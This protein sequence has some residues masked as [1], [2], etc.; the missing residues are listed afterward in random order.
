MRRARTASALLLLVG[1]ASAAALL[2]AA[3]HRL[4]EVLMRAQADLWGT[5][6][7]LGAALWAAGP[8]PRM[9]RAGALAAA[10]LALVS[11]VPRL[12]ADCR[13]VAL[14]GY[15]GDAVEG[16]AYPELL[17]RSRAVLKADPG[18]SEAAV[19]SAG[20]LAF[21]LGRPSEALTLLGEAAEGSPVDSSLAAAAAGIAA[22]GPEDAPQALSQ[23]GAC[24]ALPDCPARIRRNAAF[25]RARL[26]QQR[27]PARRQGP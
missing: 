26:L 15:Y 10:A 6:A 17:A 23:L 12:H 21:H 11:T 25:L 5:G 13:F 4:P 8:A 7:A 22:V 2:A 1:A 18:F 14:L 20:V 3:L 24:L 19:F 9:L 16:P 27:E